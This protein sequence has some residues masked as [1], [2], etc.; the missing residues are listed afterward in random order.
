MD[1]LIDKALRPAIDEHLGRIGDD[2]DL[3]AAT[4]FDFRVADL[5]M[6]SGHF[7]VAGADAMNKG[8]AG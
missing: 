8:Y 3:P 4:L 5:A 7:L 1:R 6:G 2:L